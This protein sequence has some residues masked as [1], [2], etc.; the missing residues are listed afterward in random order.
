[1][2]HDTPA[3]ASRKRFAGA[4]LRRTLGLLRK[5]CIQILRDPSS[6]IIAG[7]VPLLLLFLFSFGVSLDLKN[8]DVAVVIESTSPQASRFVQSFEG[9]RYF[10]VRVAR[11][12]RQVQ[13]QLVAGRL[14]GVVVLGSEF[15]ARAGRGEAAPV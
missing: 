11:D 1:M 5:E 15:A 10:R 9:S 8:V 14:Q 13:G 4:S 12:R 3:T 7:V 2:S 6:L